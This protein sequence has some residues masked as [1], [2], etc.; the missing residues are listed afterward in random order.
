MV[1]LGLDNIDV[2]ENGLLWVSAHPKIVDVFMYMFEQTEL[3]P[4]RVWKQ[5]EVIN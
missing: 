2:D 4:F 1:Y 3:S 5:N